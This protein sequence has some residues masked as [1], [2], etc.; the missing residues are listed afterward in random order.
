MSRMLATM[1]A[2]TL[3]TG[4][5][6]AASANTMK[7]DALVAAT[8]SSSHVDGGRDFERHKGQVPPGIAKAR[9]IE[10][11]KSKVS[12]YCP[13]HSNK[14]WRARTTSVVCDGGMGHEY[15]TASA[16]PARKLLSVIFD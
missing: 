5:T 11:W 1:A 15:C 4:L 13:G 2:L 16:T 9:A 7:C 10:A 12:T 6:T 3:A 14:W 8:A